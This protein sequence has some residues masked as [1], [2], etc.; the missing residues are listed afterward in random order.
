MAQI[1]DKSKDDKQKALNMALSQ[2]EKQFG[3]GLPD[4]SDN[5][6]HT[7]KRFFRRYVAGSENVSSCMDRHFHS[8]SSSE[9]PSHNL[10]THHSDGKSVAGPTSPDK[11]ELGKSQARS[12]PG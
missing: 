11:M 5:S 4:I 7:A 6:R 9:D 10:Q 3:K 1:D 8:E 12:C 2:I